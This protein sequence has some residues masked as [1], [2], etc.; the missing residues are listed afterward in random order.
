MAHQCLGITKMGRQCCKFMKMPGYCHMH[1]PKVLDDYS[2]LINHDELIENIIVID[3][4]NNDNKI[5]ELNEIIDQQRQEIDKMREICRAYNVIRKFEFLKMKI[6]SIVNF[7]K[8]FYIDDIC[9][10]KKYYDI[11]KSTFGMTPYKLKELYY[12]LRTE[13]NLKAHPIN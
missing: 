2:E 5:K 1:M 9:N 11:I 4:K 3:F 6:K 10:D 12:K 13:R 7:S 8:N